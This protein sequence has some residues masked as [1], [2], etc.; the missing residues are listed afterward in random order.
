MTNWFSKPYYTLA[1]LFGYIPDEDVLGSYPQDM[2]F[3]SAE[4]NRI[5]AFKERNLRWVVGGV[6]MNGWFEYGG[7]EDYDY[8]RW[9]DSHAW[10][11]DEEGNIYDYTQPCWAYYCSVNGVN[12]EGLPLGVELRGVPKATLRRLGLQYVPAPE[13]TQKRI[14]ANAF[15]RRGE[16]APMLHLVQGWKPLKRT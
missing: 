2:C 3:Y 7:K 13:A 11:E 1:E 15:K 6:G 5:T 9:Q 14:R 4:Y 12:P 8:A 10:L 16:S